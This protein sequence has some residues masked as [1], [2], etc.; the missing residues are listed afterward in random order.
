MVGTKGLR[1]SRDFGDER[2]LK[3]KTADFG[4]ISRQQIWS[5]YRVSWGY[6]GLN[7]C[8]KLQ[9]FAIVC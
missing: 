3:P 5:N 9:A 7:L 4:T 8:V 1:C 6:F 2:H